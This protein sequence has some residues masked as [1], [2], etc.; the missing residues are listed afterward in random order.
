MKYNAL[1][2]VQNVYQETP[3]MIA[4]RYNHIETVKLMIETYNVDI[5]Y[6]NGQQETALDLSV[7]SLNGSD[8]YVYLIRLYS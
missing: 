4:A 5:D 3:V 1:P 8:V 2:N 6:S 7:N